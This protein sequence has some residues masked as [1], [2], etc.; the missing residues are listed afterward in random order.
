MEAYILIYR[1]KNIGVVDLGGPPGFWQKP[2]KNPGDETPIFSDP[3]DVGTMR[4]RKVKVKGANGCNR[5]SLQGS[6]CISRLVFGEAVTW[7]TAFFFGMTWFPNVTKLPDMGRPTSHQPPASKN[8]PNSGSHLRFIKVLHGRTRLRFLWIVFLGYIQGEGSVR[9]FCRYLVAS[10][11]F[12]GMFP[13]CFFSGGRSGMFK[14]H[15]TN[16]RSVEALPRISAS[17]EVKNQWFHHVF[18]WPKRP[19]GDFGVWERSLRLL[20]VAM[21]KQ[22]FFLQWKT[23]VSTSGRNLRQGSWFTLPVREKLCES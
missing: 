13:T 8:P 17:V 10:V 19:K 20:N 22:V 7:W 6:F 5:L 16:E 1:I 9:S 23:C 15:S 12:G 4:P 14:K 3:A 2:P 11:F 18:F 21:E